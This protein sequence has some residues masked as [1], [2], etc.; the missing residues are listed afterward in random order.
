VGGLARV[1]FDILHN[2]RN[3]LALL[4]SEHRIAMDTGNGSMLD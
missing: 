2:A 3:T 1:L 4:D